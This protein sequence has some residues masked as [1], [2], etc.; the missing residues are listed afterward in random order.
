MN[1]IDRI[2]PFLLSDDRIIQDFVLHALHDYPNVSK[3]WIEQLANEAIENAEKRESILIYLSI[4]PMHEEIVHLLVKGVRSA[5]EHNKHLYYPLFEDLSPELALKYKEDLTPFIPG[6]YWDLYDMLIDGNKEDVLLEYEGILNKLEGEKY[7]HSTYYRIAKKIAYTLVKKEWI[8]EAEIEEIFKANLKEKWFDYKGT[9]SVYMFGLMK[10]DKY[11]HQLASLLVRDE[12][13]LLEEVAATLISFQT[14]EVVEAVAPYILKEESN[15]FATSIVENMKTDYAI[16][17]LRNSYHQAID[18]DVQA[19]IIEALA[20]QLSTKG[21]PEI[22]DYVSKRPTTFLLDI[23]Q[24]AYSYYK[25]IGIDH[26]LLE[27]WKVIIEKEENNE[28]MVESAFS[29]SVEMKK[30]GRNEPCPCGSGK[31]YKKCCG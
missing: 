15:I 3:N 26:P 30:V 23:E 19:T 13:I 10:T 28:E 22:N 20:H 4:D 21:E 25:M 6:G 18:E 7:H 9:L 29:Q 24:L 5:P 16:E 2:K 31:K 11:L 1:F 8:T 27:E 12:D 17:V 14:D